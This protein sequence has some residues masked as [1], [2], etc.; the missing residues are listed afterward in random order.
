MI[1]SLLLCAVFGVQGLFECP[2]VRPSR[3]VQGLGHAWMLH[4]LGHLGCLGRGVL[5][6]LR[7]ESRR[8]LDGGSD[9]SQCGAHSKSVGRL[10]RVRRTSLAPDPRAQ[11]NAQHQNVRSKWARPGDNIMAHSSGFR[12]LGG[13]RV[14][15]GTLCCWRFSERFRR[16]R[17]LGHA[18]TVPASQ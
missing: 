12:A 4:R 6:T 10:D 18:Y 5:A 14:S 9:R 7:Q 2:R 13:L 3:P 17:P 1:W 16:H 15:Y 8:L 11:C